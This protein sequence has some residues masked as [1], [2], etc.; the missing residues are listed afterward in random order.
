MQELTPLQKKRLGQTLDTAEGGILG[1]TALIF[2]VEDKIDLTILEVK[3]IKDNVS[4]LEQTVKD[5]FDEVR[6]DILA[7]QNKEEPLTEQEIKDIAVEAEKLVDKDIIAKKTFDLIPLKDISDK[8]SKD[9]KVPIVEKIVERIIEKT[10]VIRETPIVTN[11]IKEVAVAEEADVIVKKLQSLSGEE[12]LDASAIKNLPSGKVVGGANSPQITIKDEGVTKTKRATSINFVGAGVT[13]TASSGD[14]TVTILGGGQVN[15]IVAGTG[16]SVDSTD[17]VN[18]VVNNSNPTPYTLP[19]A[20]AS[21]LGGVKIGARLT[22]TGDTLSAD[23]QGVSFATIFPWTEITA[24]TKNLEI[25]NGYIASRATLLTFTLPTTSVVGSIIRVIGKGVGGWE[26]AQNAS[27]QIIWNEGGVD[28]K[29]ETTVGVGG[30]LASVDDNDAIEII[31]LTADL[32]WGVL[33]SK[34]N[35]SL[36]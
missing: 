15:T 32:L 14:V 7:E 4:V 30:K 18:P 26:L 17:P 27:Q 29:D 2:E 1:V 3:D 21:V 5:N 16:I 31:C 33:S 35:I 23:V 11:E 22:M 13:S 28:G 10:E 19:T 24:S 12:R 36:T 6:S 20:S 34:G 8:I 9:I 25:N